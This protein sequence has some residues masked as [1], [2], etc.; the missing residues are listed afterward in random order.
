MRSIQSAILTNRRTRE[1][2]A[3]SRWGTTMWTYLLQRKGMGRVRRSRR[4]VWSTTTIISSHLCFFF[5]GWPC[6]ASGDDLHDEHTSW[7]YRLASFSADGAVVL[8]FSSGALLV[9]RRRPQAPPPAI[10]PTGAGEDD[11]EERKGKKSSM[12]GRE[13]GTATT[14]TGRVMATTNG[15]CGGEAM[16]QGDGAPPARTRGR[17]EQFLFYFLSPSQT[18]S[19]TCR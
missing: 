7:H 8:R 15:S 17:R 12:S 4:G 6:S 10:A 1:K 5:T 3:A 2:P 16:G 14:T 11:G 13:E 19:K 18:L 9:G